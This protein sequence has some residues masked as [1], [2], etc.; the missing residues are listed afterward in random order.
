MNV[1]DIAIRLAEVYSQALFSLASESDCVEQVKEDVDAIAAIIDNDADF[2]SLMVSPYFS[3]QY[4]QA[5][6]VKAFS[7]RF[8][9]LTTNFL[10]IVIEHER[11]VFLPQILD[12]FNEHWDALH[13]RAVV[14]VT[15]SEP[16]D[17]KELAKLTIDISVTMNRPADVV[18]NV[19]PEIIGGAVINYGDSI[20]DNSIRGRL[21]RAVTAV[22]GRAKRGL[23]VNEV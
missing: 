5:L 23:E 9:E 3:E 20:I 12:R 6:V 4:K 11:T 13:G 18:M 21:A 2:I 1:N 17:E 22:T 16:I 10:K 15:V 7:G 19:N 14:K 8:N